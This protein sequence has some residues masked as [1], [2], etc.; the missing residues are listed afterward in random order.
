MATP[1]GGGDSSHP[2]PS[3]LTYNSGE[4][5]SA[6]TFTEINTLIESCGIPTSKA[7][8]MLIKY[9]GQEDVLLT[10]LRNLSMMSAGPP[11]L[12]NNNNSSG[13]EAVQQEEE[14][15]PVI[16]SNSGPP[17]QG[18]F[19]HLG[20][21][22]LERRSF[23]ESD[24]PPPNGTH[25]ID[26]SD[27]DEDIEQD[28]SNAQDRSTLYPSSSYDGVSG[29]FQH[30]PSFD[31]KGKFIDYANKGS[32]AA[33]AA[34]RGLDSSDEL[35]NGTNNLH[36]NGNSLQYDTPTRA[37]KGNKKYWYGGGAIVL[38]TVL[39]V[40]IVFLVAPSGD[41]Q[42][43]MNPTPSPFALS[44]TSKFAN[45]G[46]DAPSP[47]SSDAVPKAPSPSGYTPDELEELS[48]YGWKYVQDVKIGWISWP[49]EYD[50]DTFLYYNKDDGVSDLISCAKKCKGEDAPTG[51]K[52]CLLYVLL[53]VCVYQ[54]IILTHTLLLHSPPI[55]PKLIY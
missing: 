20:V 4:P 50:T 27:D 24:T 43:L 29:D 16:D 13:G 1:E 25:T 53:R 15:V 11:P 22:E 5:A 2:S 18:V 41:N 49:Q 33:L 48:N 39:I 54:G 10:N 23:N 42:M 28:F 55:Y 52:F 38:L 19:N 12:T 34:I 46:V 47:D 9:E 8:E 17:S 45:M 35:E 31:S 6:E 14:G 40:M 3:G 30:K 51:G 32:G 37:P 21:M 36:S 26:D 7:N 44:P